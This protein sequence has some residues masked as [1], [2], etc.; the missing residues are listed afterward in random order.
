MPAERVSAALRRVVMERAADLCEYCRSPA[1]FATQSF[2]VEHIVPRD[3]GGETTL[4]NLAWACFGCNSHKHT[5]TRGVDPV[6]G[7]QAAL[8]HPREQSW[9]DHFAWSDDFTRVRG[10]TPQ[11]RVTV[12]ALQLNRAG[13]V[14]LRRVL[15]A[16]G[17]HPPPE[18]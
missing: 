14:N 7:E 13:L 6:S 11:G 5:T 1:A 9:S 18:R 17:A 16:A 4:G 12:E 2:T 3:A 10:T 8:F 15:A